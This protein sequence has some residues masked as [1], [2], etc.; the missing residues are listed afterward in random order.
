MHTPGPWLYD[1]NHARTMGLIVEK[2]GSTI[3]ELSAPENSTA[4]GDLE[5]NARLIAA[6]PDMLDALEKCRRWIG[7]YHDLPGHD[8]ASRCM[9][10]YLDKIISTTT[11]E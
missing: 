2:D 11:G 5:S 6:A 3:V 9:T 4:Q 1:I 10:D 8:A 7:Q